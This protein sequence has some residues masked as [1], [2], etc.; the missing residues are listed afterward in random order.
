MSKLLGR[1]AIQICPPMAMT[2]AASAESDQQQ[3]EAGG[4]PAP[5][6]DALRPDQPVRPALDVAGEKRG[7]HEHARD[8][9]GSDQECP[10]AGH[11][12]VHRSLR[13]GA[14]PD[15]HANQRGGSRRRQGAAG[16]RRLT[17]A[18]PGEPGRPRHAG[19]AAGAGRAPTEGLPR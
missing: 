12:G 19:I 8:P 11:Q 14:L 13:L 15:R 10:E 1:R 4:R 18:A 3:G 9:W 16:D 6:G 2:A 5:A 17:V 7:S